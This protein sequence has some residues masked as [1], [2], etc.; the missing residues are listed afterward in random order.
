[1]VAVSVSSGPVVAGAVDVEMNGDAETSQRE[2]AKKKMVR[3]RM[4]KRRWRRARC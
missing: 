4:P 2:N 1:M 3:G